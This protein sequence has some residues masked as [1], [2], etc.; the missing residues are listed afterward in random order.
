MAKDIE[1][2][3]EKLEKQNRKLKKKNRAGV[4]IILF[5]L[6]IIVILAA[7][8]F[9]LDPFGWGIGP[10]AKGGAGTAGTAP[11]QGEAAVTTAAAEAETTTEEPKAY[12]DI[13]VIG[14]T[15]MFGTEETTLDD[16]VKVIKD[17]G[18]E[19]IVNITDRDSTQ[20]AMNDLIKRL[21]EE[22]IKYIMK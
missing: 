16:F 14:S 13:D 5:L 20:N 21:D 10:N 1:Q 11:A 3:N 22:G 6:L 2:E 8:L 17:Y 4:K 9:F 15:Y 12:T 18:E 7:L 19:V